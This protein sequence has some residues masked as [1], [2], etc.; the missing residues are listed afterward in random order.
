MYFSKQDVI[1]VLLTFSSSSS[2]FY[3]SGNADARERDRGA[4]PARLGLLTWSQ[5]TQ[6]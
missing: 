1:F 2:F 3:L 5:K 4:R 6:V